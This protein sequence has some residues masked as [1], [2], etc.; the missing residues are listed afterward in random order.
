M[1]SRTTP[2][3]PYASPHNVIQKIGAVQKDCPYHAQ[4][5]VLGSVGLCVS[6]RTMVTQLACA[7][8]QVP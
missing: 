6:R 8:C 2:V 5:P 1:I 4:Y 7:V 3:F